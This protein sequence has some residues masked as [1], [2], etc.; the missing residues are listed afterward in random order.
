[1]FTA[2]TVLFLFLCCMSIISCTLLSPGYIMLYTPT[3][4]T[5]LTN[6]QI[7]TTPLFF[8]SSG[9][10]VVRAS[11]CASIIEVSP[12]VLYVDWLRTTRANHHIRWPWRLIF[13]AEQLERIVLSYCHR[14]PTAYLSVLSDSED[15][16]WTTPFWGNSSF[17]GSQTTSGWSWLHQGTCLWRHLLL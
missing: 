10:V 1:M 2:L 7:G 15:P 17:S 9:C 13:M 6:T 8:V 5:W 14:P 4:N 16:I 3:H 11:T 12:L